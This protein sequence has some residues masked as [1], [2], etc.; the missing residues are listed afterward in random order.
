MRIFL[1]RP[2][3]VL[4]TYAAV[5]L[6]GFLSLQQLAVD[7][8]PDLNYPR[9]LI[10]THFGEASPQEVQE[11]VTR[12]I[13]EAVSAVSGIKRIS[14]IS[15]EGLSLVTLTFYWGTR[16]DYAALAVREA[17][18]EI[19]PLLPE[20]TDRPRVLRVDPSALPIMQ[21]AVRGASLRELT[22]LCQQVVRRRLE[23]IKGVAMVTVVGGITDEIE[24]LVDF[25]KLVVQGFQI[26]DIVEVLKQNNVAL[27]GGTIKQGRYRRAIRIDARLRSVEDIGKLALYTP[28]AGQP[29]YLRDVATIRRIPAEPTNIIRINGQPAVGLLITREAG[30]NTVET[31]RRVQALLQEIRQLYPVLEFDIV[32]NQATFIQQS[33]RNVFSSL[34]W[35]G[36]LAFLVLFLFLKNFW[37]PLT[38]GVSIPVSIIATFIAMHF[39]GVSVNMMSLGGLALGIGMLVDNSI[40]VLENIFRHREEGKDLVNAASSGASEVAMPILASTLTTCAVFLPIIYVKGVA[41]QLFRDQS[42]AVTFALITSWVVSLTL[43]PVLASR[44]RGRRV[45]YFAGESGESGDSKRRR[46]RLL[47]GMLHI[48]GI[49]WE[50]GKRIFAIGQRIVGKYWAGVHNGFERGFQ[51]V[52]RSYHRLLLYALENKKT[53]LFCVMFLFGMTVILATRLDRRL[54]PPIESQEVQY[55]LQLPE[56]ATLTRTLEVVNTI[57]Q[58]FLQV[59]GVSMVYSRIGGLDQA[60]RA[61][62]EEGDNRAVLLIRFEGTSPSTLNIV[63]RL[64][65]A[66][67]KPFVYE[68]NFIGGES[69]YRHILG[70]APSDFEVDVRGR[71]LEEILPLAQ[72]IKDWMMA[73]PDFA[74][75]TWSHHTGGVQLTAKLD[76]NK[77]TQLGLSAERVVQAVRQRLGGVQATQI[78]E[79]DRTIHVVVKSDFDQQVRWQDVQNMFIASQGMFIPVREIIRVQHSPAVEQLNRM[80]QEA[81]IRI[82]ASLPQIGRKQAEEKLSAWLQGQSLPP[83]V[84]VE[85]GGDY[86]EMQRSLRSIQ[87][88]LALSVILVYMILAAQFESLIYPF[89]ILITVP[90][91]ILG[92]VWMLGLWG[93]SWNVIS[94]IG[95]IVLAG[96][97]VNDGILKVDF[98][99]RA[100]AAGKSVREAILEASRKRFRP[101]VITTVTT[102]LGLIPMAISGGSGA[103]LRRPLAIVVMGGLIVATFFTLVFIPLVYEWVSRRK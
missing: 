20:E 14:S 69:V 13:E 41:G 81:V 61:S 74:D 91:G 65:R 36:V 98:I 42:L 19:R 6:L 71:R 57:E 15:R 76:R 9:L 46:G 93:E 50:V 11:F 28:N 62:E 44:F 53:V 94:G 45:V 38:I 99:N 86:Q 102:V 39:A 4:M 90:L 67:P 22:D 43:L 87:L 5:L 33:I 95:F 70:I 17:L 92:G 79:Y 66:L 88:A 2:I 97:V 49:G 68:G 12:P 80:D 35:G 75:V 85:P 55:H 89:I 84:R 59:P 40:V 37:H 8:F 77:L 1:H 30:S 18:D 72:R 60:F 34:I 52:Y 58:R 7:L 31:A 56:G 78:R 47:R 23:Q 27:T 32:S 25:P 48:A 24:I 63:E 64:R 100:R 54:F 16:M 21:I 73:D 26:Q 103:E 83:D 51:Q 29:V 96:I 82:T 10:R 101:I 3:A